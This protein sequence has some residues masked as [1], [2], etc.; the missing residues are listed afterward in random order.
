[1]IVIDTERLRL[2]HL[3]VDLATSILEGPR[4]TDWAGEFP[5]SGERRLA[6]WTLRV[7][8]GIDD[9]PFNAYVVRERTSSRLIGSAGF[10]AAPVDETVEIG[11]GLV[12]AARGKGY[13]TEA[14]IALVE[15][16]FATGQIRRVLAS[17][18]ERN[19]ASHRVLVRCGF[20]PVGDR[21]SVWERVLL[22]DL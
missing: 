12:E 7:G 5:G 21:P 19:V 6:E 4:R 3:T 20:T 18:D 14:C 22:E 17:V 1:V 16:A 13:A 11:Y 2:E 8:D 15:T 9:A 10:H